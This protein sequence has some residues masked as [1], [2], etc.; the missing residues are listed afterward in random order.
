MKVLV[1][2]ASKHGATAEIASVIGAV[3]EAEHVD[4]DVLAPE[5]VERVDGYG[6][7][8]LGSGVYAGHWL[9]PAKQFVDRHEAGLRERPLFV[10]SSGPV[11][12]PPKE[13][14]EPAEIAAVD[15]TFHPI[16][17]RVF[18]GRLTASQLGPF[19]KLIIGIVKA[20]LSDDRPWDDIADWAKAIA[21]YV[22]DEQPDEAPARQV[23]VPV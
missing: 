14:D 11:G 23:L 1:T 21:R 13:S 22:K 10:F 20:P 2:A 3:L 4:V 6:A 8:V 15:A 16:D 7:V 19:E 12:Q 9:K 17:H 5:Q 18:G